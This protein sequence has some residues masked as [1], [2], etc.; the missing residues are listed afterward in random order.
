VSEPKTLQT[1]ILELERRRR[2]DPLKNVYKPND[3]QLLAHQSRH[4]I[5]VVLGGNR[6]GKSWCAVAECILYALGR[7]V[8]AKLVNAA[9][10]HIEV[11]LT[12][13]YVVPSLTQFRRSIRPIFRQLLPFGETVKWDEQN[14]VIIFHNGSEIHI[15]SADM[16][17]RRLAGAAVDFIV[18]DEPIAK[19]V[20]EELQARLIST[21]G[22]LLMV[23]TPVDEDMTKW[24]WIRDE[25]YVPATL[26]ERPDVNIIHM[27]VADEEGNPLVPHLTRE[28]I[29][30]IE[31]QYPDPLVRAA[32]MYGEFVTRS[33]LV[34]DSF[35]P[36]LHIVEPFE[37]PRNWHRWLVVDPQYHRF[38]CLFFAADEDGNYYVWHEYFSQ[39][40]LLSQ[41]AQYISQ[42]LGELEKPIPCYVDY[43]NPQDIAE[44]NENFRKLGVPV[45]AMPLPYQKKIEKML[46][47][48]HAM[49][50]PQTHRKYHPITGQGHIYGAPRLLFFGN[51][52]S[53]W[54]YNQQVQRNSRLMWEMKRLTWDKMGK[55]DKRSADGADATDCLIYGCTILASGTRLDLEESWRDGLNE[56]DVGIWEAI[57]R[58]DKKG[59]YDGWN[60][61]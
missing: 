54:R 55:P 58:F 21:R 53:T 57:D 46:L 39:N 23:L 37:I 48:T 24:L 60:W 3:G 30:R 2:V 56:R 36:D 29:E 50:E 5:T 51:L 6:T 31:R 10:E 32:R 16:R 11:P 20:F 41:R 4:E 59:A 22:R 61:Q 19:V 43:A 18:V 27:P 7:E 12:I 38:A 13:W 33:G 26:G 49:L 28:D 15:V 35:D 42:A 25:L 40:E 8:Y 34:L 9:N 44:L 47:R 14:N 52:E 1:A 45:G 17:Q